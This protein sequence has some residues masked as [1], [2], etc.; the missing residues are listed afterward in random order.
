MRFGIKGKDAT[1]IHF[2]KYVNQLINQSPIQ[3]RSFRNTGRL[4]ERKEFQSMLSKVLEEA[5]WASNMRVMGTSGP[6][7]LAW[8]SR[9][10]CHSSPSQERRQTEPIKVQTKS[11]S[12]VRVKNPT[13]TLNV[14]PLMLFPIEARDYKV[15]A[16]CISISWTSLED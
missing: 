15:L 5:Q 4:A 9:R 10:S 3:G 6:A 16:G 14:S 1:K 11:A 13:T 2:N 7:A 12:G 8:A